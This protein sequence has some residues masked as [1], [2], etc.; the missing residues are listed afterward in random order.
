MVSQTFIA[1]DL[2]SAIWDLGLLSALECSNPIRFPFDTQLR[3]F[4]AKRSQVL[5]ELLQSVER[6]CGFSKDIMSI[7]SD[8]SPWNCQLSTA[9]YDRDRL[10]G[11]LL[12]AI[13]ES[14][15]IEF[16]YDNQEFILS[17]IER[18]RGLQI[19]RMI[20][21]ALQAR[22]CILGKDTP[23]SHVLKDVVDNA[24][25]FSNAEF[26]NRDSIPITSKQVLQKW[27][28]ENQ[29]RKP[30]VNDLGSGYEKWKISVAIPEMS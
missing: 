1:R 10:N 15:W 3:Q 11:E 17:I 18:G 16:D 7:A 27:I 24:I 21:N 2:F 26:S 12:L 6:F 5:R 23:F 20:D 29:Y 13:H 4:V 14:S 28:D 30:E 9:P 22:Y 8:G 25:D 19:S